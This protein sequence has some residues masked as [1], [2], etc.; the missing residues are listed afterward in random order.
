[1]ALSKPIPSSMDPVYTPGT[2]RQ[3]KLVALLTDEGTALVRK[4]FEDEVKK[5]SPPSLREQLKKH[6]RYLCG[7]RYLSPALRNTLYPPD[8]N[9]SDTAEGF[10][11]SLLE[12][13]LK[14]LVRLELRRDAPYSGERDRLRRFRNE[15]GHITSTDLSEADFDRLWEELTGILVALGGDRDKISERLNRSIDPELERMYFAMQEKLYKQERLEEG[16]L[17]TSTSVPTEVEMGGPEMMALYEQACKDGTTDYYYIRLILTGK[18]G[19][20]KSSLQN[21]LLQ[22]EFNMNEESTDGIVITP[23]LMTGK[24]QWKM[25]KA[26]PVTS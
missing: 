13:L 24:E 12:L 9:V 14:N 22:L 16:Q 10:N 4:I 26:T 18:H 20:G 21:S 19:N 15:H 25:T 6:K 17:I 5:M 2:A 1:M 23:C 3:A 8:G 11:I 7:S